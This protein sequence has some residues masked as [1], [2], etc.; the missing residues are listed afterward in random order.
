[1]ET[2]LTL[3]KVLSHVIGWTVLGFVVLL[4]IGPVFAVV[5]AILP[6]ALVGFLCWAGY[7]GIRRLTHQAKTGVIDERIQVVREKLAPG[8]EWN[9]A[10]RNGIGAARGGVG[11]VLRLPGSLVALLATALVRLP[12]AIL[13]LPLMILRLPIIA[14]G[15]VGSQVWGVASSVGR[16]TGRVVTGAFA[17]GRFA[18]VI[19]LEVFCGI[20]VG[21]LLGG[22]AE[23]RL[24]LHGDMVLTGAAVGGFLGVLVALS[25][26]EPRRKTS[27][28]G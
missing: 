23:Q 3:G 11:R 5:G 27:V 28:A 18:A 21:A 13:R 10:A 12:V 24:S 4:V 1:M 17:Q 8:G 20:A 9:R 22:L 26:P 16:F 25:T 7:R 14:L 2:Q 15:W 6:F 19:V